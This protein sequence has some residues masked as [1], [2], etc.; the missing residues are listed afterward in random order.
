VKPCALFPVDGPFSEYLRL[1]GIADST[2][3]VTL[4]NLRRVFRGAFG[5][6][7]EAGDVVLSDEAVQRWLGDQRAALS[8]PAL[9]NLAYAWSRYVEFLGAVYGVHLPQAPEPPPVEDLP[10]CVFR[11]VELLR[12]FGAGS[13][14]WQTARWTPELGAELERARKA[15]Q[16]TPGGILSL[17][18]ED[19]LRVTVGEALRL[20]TPY[21]APSGWRPGAPFLPDVPGGA[22]PMTPARVRALEKLLRLG[23]T[24]R[25]TKI[26][27][28]RQARELAQVQGG[29]DRGRAREMA[30]AMAA[31]A[32]NDQHGAGSAA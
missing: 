6:A 16:T 5:E 20:L 3:T 12:T 26:L 31:D 32:G 27:K 10:E 14:Y 8:G 7:A 11:G 4:S 17:S 21:S 30:V 29:E 28:L 9:A 25:A 23:P 24:D 22:H 2:R 19:S 13:D 1:Q 15:V 18:R